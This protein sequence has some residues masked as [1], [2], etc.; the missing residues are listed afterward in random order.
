MRALLLVALLAGCASSG[1][2]KVWAKDGATSQEFTIAQAK[3]RG[4]VAQLPQSADSMDNITMRQL[5]M[6]NCMV[7]GGWTLR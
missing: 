5:T 7:A 3:C 4:Q 1:P 2:P 6:N